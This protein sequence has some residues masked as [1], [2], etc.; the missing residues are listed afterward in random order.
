MT[1]CRCENRPHH[2]TG[3]HALSERQM[4]ARRKCF[5]PQEIPP[6]DATP[7]KPALFIDRYDYPRRAGSVI[8]PKLPAHFFAPP[9]STASHP[10]L[11]GRVHARCGRH[12]PSASADWNFCRGAR[13]SLERSH[14]AASPEE[15]HM[16]NIFY[17]IGVVV[18]IALVLGYLGL[19]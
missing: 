14:G 4:N 11:T 10:H 6:C 19:T 5:Y 7:C 17:I 8:P 9:A 1:C 15:R 12:E 2:L 3:T 13:L 16:S 18:V